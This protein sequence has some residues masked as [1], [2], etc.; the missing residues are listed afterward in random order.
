MKV[1]M[2]GHPNGFRPIE[3]L[4]KVERRLGRYVPAST[5]R[6]N[7]HSNAAFER[8]GPGPYQLRNR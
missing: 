6:D 2:A 5:V 7:L 4:K 8:I 3:V 1:V